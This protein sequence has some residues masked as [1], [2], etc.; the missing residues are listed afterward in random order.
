MAWAKGRLFSGDGGRDGGIGAKVGRGGDEGW[1]EW[2]ED[3]SLT[4]SQR[5]RL[6]GKR[7]CASLTSLD[8]FLLNPAAPKLG[9]VSGSR[10]SSSLAQKDL[11]MQREKKSQNPKTRYHWSSCPLS[12]NIENVFLIQDGQNYDKHKDTIC[13]RNFYQLCVSFPLEERQC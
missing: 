2:H 6:P 4:A 3:T 13:E 9:R 7:G 8:I 10:W 5:W 11:F 1:W 12:R